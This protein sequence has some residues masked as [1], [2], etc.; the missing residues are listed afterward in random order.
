MIVVAVSLKTESGDDYLFL[1][2]HEEIVKTIVDDMGDDVEYVW[3][4][5]IKVYPYDSAVDR[6]VRDKL[7]EARRNV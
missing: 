5:D 4:M 6:N 2:N 7:N 3:N 1:D